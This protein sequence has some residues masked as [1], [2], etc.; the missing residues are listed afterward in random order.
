MQKICY[1]RQAEGGKD[2]IQSSRLAG[3]VAC[4]SYDAGVNSSAE[5]KFAPLTK[6]SLTDW[7]TGQLMHASCCPWLAPA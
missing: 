3:G 7:S 1:W 4:I 2:A 6:L 5:M